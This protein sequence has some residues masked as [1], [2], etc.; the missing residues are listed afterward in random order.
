GVA[1]AHAEGAI[2]EANDSFLQTIGRSKDDLRAGRIRWTEMTASGSEDASAA[3][4]A[5]LATHGVAHPFEKEYVHADGRRVPVL[6]AAATLEGAEIISVCLD[7]SERK[8]LE[9]QL[10]RAQKMEAIG[11]LA[12][13]VAHDFNNLLSVIL[14][15]TGLL[16]EQLAKGDPLRADIEEI[17]KAG[18]RGADLT[19]QL[20]TFSRRAMQQPRAVDPN[21]VLSGMQRMLRRIL[22]EDVELSIQTDPDAGTVYA[23]PGQIE[24][25]VMN[26]VVNARDAM[27]A[28]GR[29]RIETS[30]VSLTDVVA[31]RHV[32]VAP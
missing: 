21:S 15:Y 27:P 9:E 6:L 30:G 2:F 22:C 25:V 4:L 24:Q 29:L 13:G 20:L 23:D 32:G 10:R 18:E 19:R 8:R 3:A 28:G 1:I 5:N 14:S 11:T 12:G 17:Q 26:L 31:A 7:L 16:T